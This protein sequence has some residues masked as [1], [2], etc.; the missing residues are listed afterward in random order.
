MTSSATRAVGAIIVTAV[1]LYVLWLSNDSNR[2]MLK[3]LRETSTDIRYGQYKQQQTLNRIE[4]RLAK[5][6]SQYNALR[7][8]LG[9]NFGSTLTQA[10]EAKTPYQNSLQ[11]AGTA[12]KNADMESAFE[13]LTNVN[14][15]LLDRLKFVEEKAAGNSSALQKLRH[16]IALEV[17]WLL[18]SLERN[19]R[20]ELILFG[21]PLHSTQRR[22]K[23][24]R[25]SRKTSTSSRSSF[26]APFQALSK[27]IPRSAGLCKDFLPQTQIYSRSATNS[28][29]FRSCCVN[30]KKRRKS[31]TAPSRSLPSNNVLEMILPKLEA[32]CVLALLCKV[33]LTVAKH[34]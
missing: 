15:D 32:R 24:I 7:N 29:E 18:L 12:L 19:A 5:A 6:S 23:L 20:V 34:R 21:T 27:S 22:R 26:R 2:H 16:D 13:A 11:K 31:T 8:S 30:N 33:I 10:R 9:D 3:A 1:F 4:Y 17:C 14:H 25:G 28:P